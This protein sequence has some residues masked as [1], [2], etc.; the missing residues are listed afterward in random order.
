MTAAKIPKQPV[1]TPPRRTADDALPPLPPEF[2]PP[3]ADSPRGRILNAA[4]ELFA[5]RGL[6]ATSTRAIAEAAGV[7]L[8]MIHYYY[9]NKERLYEHV[10][11]GALLPLVR[12]MMAS[13]RDERAADDALLGM[14]FRIMQELRDRPQ[15]A[16]LLRRDIAAGATHLRNVIVRLGEHGPLHGAQLFAG[17]VER[18]VSQGR[19]RK[20]DPNT[21]RECLLVVA[22]GSMLV[23]PV[24]SVFYGRDQSDDWHW[25]KWQQT[26]KTLLRHGLL[27]K[28]SL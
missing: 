3:A 9:Q 23:D 19:I 1:H 25:D 11:A 10:L 6:K 8:A 27:V 12:S 22:F 14:P 16:A 20:L 21:L 15:L 4:G 18:A 24:V 28:E 13:F 26:W 17:V 2:Q 7:N 5:T